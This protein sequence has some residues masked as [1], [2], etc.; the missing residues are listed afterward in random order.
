MIILD[1]QNSPGGKSIASSMLIKTITGRANQ[2]AIIKEVHV[3]TP[4]S[5]ALMVNSWQQTL[6]NSSKGSFKERKNIKKGLL[7]A[8]ERYR[9]SIETPWVEP[10]GVIEDSVHHR[11]CKAFNKWI[12][13]PNCHSPV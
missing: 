1:L 8:K 10:W 9:E 2:T 7:E 13:R 11:A 5:L 6:N 4:W 12:S 3:Q